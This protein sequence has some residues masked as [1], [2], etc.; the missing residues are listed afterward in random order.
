MN[1]R[2]KQGTSD[3][4]LLTEDERTLFR[5]TVGEVTP[6][7]AHAQAP[8]PAP[9][10]PARPALPRQV[11]LPAAVPHLYPVAPLGGT[12]CAASF[13]APGITHGTFAR[14]CRG[15]LEIQASLDL[16]G[17]TVRSAHGVLEGFLDVCCRR[18][19]TCVA[20]IH[21]KG[22]RSED[23]QGVLRELVRFTL[24]GHA[25]VLAYCPARGPTIHGETWVLLRRS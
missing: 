12:S 24:R 23:R 25:S 10:Q 21:G 22:Q 7:P 18:R 8:R 3:R 5:R 17:L 11:S 15:K 2:L 9:R 16:H 14:L 19:L 13:R 1:A 4:E 6:L 20:I